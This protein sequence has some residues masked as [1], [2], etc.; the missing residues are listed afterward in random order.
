MATLRRFNVTLFWYHK[1]KAYTSLMVI[2]VKVVGVSGTS[3][4]FFNIAVDS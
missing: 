3:I 2:T 1:N 4:G